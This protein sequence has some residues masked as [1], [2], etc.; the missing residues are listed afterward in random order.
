MRA[1]CPL[2][3]AFDRWVEREVMVQAR[4]HLWHL[5]PRSDR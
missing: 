3:H 2:S 4:V 1:L 5:E